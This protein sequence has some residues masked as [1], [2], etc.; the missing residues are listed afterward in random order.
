MRGIK[1]SLKLSF[2]LL[3]ISL[4]LAPLLFQFYHNF[5]STHSHEVCIKFDIQVYEKPI[6]CSLFDYQIPFFSFDF[7]NLEFPT[8]IERS[9]EPITSFKSLFTYIIPTYFSLRGPPIIL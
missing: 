4:L 7:Y 8:Y 6:D 2:S 5:H 3:A 1:N 9:Y